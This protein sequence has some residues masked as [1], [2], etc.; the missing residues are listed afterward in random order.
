MK[1]K[2]EID[3]VIVIPIGPGTELR[4]V[5]D[6]IDSLY[7]Y[8]AH[9]FQIIIADDSGQQL[10][11]QVKK[12]FPAADLI[13]TAKNNGRYGGLYITLSIAY[14][15]AIEHYHFKALFKVDTDALIIGNA[16]E[17][18][19]VALFASQPHIGMAG[20]YGK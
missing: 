14:R 1:N 2:T 6:T 18:E 17:K 3:L 13:K 7:Y 5:T 12:L 19:A 4:F 16:P 10:G 8:A 20:Q 11:D 15:Y 9:Q